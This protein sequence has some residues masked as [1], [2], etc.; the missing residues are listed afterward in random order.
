MK[1]FTRIDRAITAFLAP[2][3]T[4]PK[5]KRWLIPHEHVAGLLDA[6]EAFHNA[7]ITTPHSPQV[8]RLCYALNKTLFDLVPK[9]AAPCR[10]ELDFKQW[11]PAIV[12]WP[13][14]EERIAELK[15]EERFQEEMQNNDDA[16]TTQRSEKPTESVSDARYKLD[17][18]TG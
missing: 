12:M 3:D 14:S 9:S 7:R 10:Y 15:L 17:D 5:P 4:P 18:Y 6:Y 13:L 11:R 2:I 8:R 16:N 1:L